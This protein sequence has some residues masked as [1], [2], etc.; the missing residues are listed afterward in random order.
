MEILLDSI[1]C[2]KC[3]E[4]AYIDELTIIIKVNTESG[5]EKVYYCEKCGE[6]Y[7]K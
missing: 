4:L 2:K 5:P 3:G 6:V 7:F 1:Q